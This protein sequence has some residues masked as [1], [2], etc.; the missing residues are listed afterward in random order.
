MQPSA[1][2]HTTGRGRPDPATG[3]VYVEVS[4]GGPAPDDWAAGLANDEHG[5][6]LMI[7]DHV[8]AAHGDRQEAGQA[9]H[10]AHI[11]HA[12]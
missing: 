6:G 1:T 12:A 5:R 8:T 2:G 9:I 10:W 11:A 7:I 3:H 4:D